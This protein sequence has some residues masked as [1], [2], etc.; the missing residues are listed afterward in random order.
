MAKKMTATIVNSAIV[1]TGKNGKLSASETF[2]FNT[3]S[4]CQ[5]REMNVN[6][7]IVNRGHLGSLSFS[8]HFCYFFRGGE[9]RGGPVAP[10]DRK[11]PFSIFASKPLLYIYLQKNCCPIIVSCCHFLYNSVVDLDV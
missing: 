6:S 2:I 4:H 1:M 3:P 5:V 10:S 7:L 11:W 8:N 9:G